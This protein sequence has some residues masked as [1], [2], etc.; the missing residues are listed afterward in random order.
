MGKIHWYKR[1]PR[2]ALTGMMELTLEERGA[3]NTVLDLIY[4]RGGD[5]PD[6]ERFIAG[7]CRCDVRVWKRI[8]ERLLNLG[9]LYVANG[10]LHNSRA[11]AG[12][13]EAL[14]R[15]ASAEEAG[16][17]SALKRGAKLKKTKRIAPTADAAGVATNKESEEDSL[18]LE[19]DDAR[20]GASPDLAGLGDQFDEAK[21]KPR[22][23]TSS[24]RGTR[25]P[26]NFC[27]DETGRAYAKDLG[28]D[29]TIFVN[30]VKKFRNHWEAKA[31][32]DALK[33]NWQ[34]AWRAWCDRWLEWSREQPPKPPRNGGG[35]PKPLSPDQKRQIDARL[36]EEGLSRFDIEGMARFNQLTEEMTRDQRHAAAA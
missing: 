16:R 15:I 1:D 19:R 35:Q 8:R 20:E 24:T 33:A 17:A 25:L 32:K 4:D 13:L 36:R 14:G 28:M 7:W 2:A 6:D 31:G 3:Y 10:K 18:S 12:L 26:R 22:K 9:K 34:A 29:R 11:D 5:L 27:P 30:Q 23:R 21:P